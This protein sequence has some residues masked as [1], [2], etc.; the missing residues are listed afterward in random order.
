MLTPTKLTSQITPPGTVLPGA[1]SS[2]PSSPISTFSG[3]MPTQ[4]AL[5]SACARSVG[6][7]T[8]I[9][10]MSTVTRSEARPLILP[11]IRLDW[12]RKLATNVLRGFS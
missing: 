5:P 1:S 3:R 12:P 8:S 4:P 7:V 6:T 9:P 2:A 11:S 10:C